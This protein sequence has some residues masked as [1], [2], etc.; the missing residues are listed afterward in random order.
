M[1]WSVVDNEQGSFELREERRAGGNGRW[2][3]TSLW[4]EKSAAPHVLL[5]CFYDAAF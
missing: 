2:E 1:T 5:V 4:V 3:G